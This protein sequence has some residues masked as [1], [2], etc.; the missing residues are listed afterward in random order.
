[1]SDD[2]KGRKSIIAGAHGEITDV[3]EFNLFVL[4]NLRACG[5]CPYCFALEGRSIPST[6]QQTISIPVG[7]RLKDIYFCGLLKKRLFFIMLNRRSLRIKVMQNLFALQQCKDANYELCFEK[8][9]ETFQPDLNSMET[10]D[11]PL[12]NSQ[13]KEARKVFEKA[14]EA[15]ETSV[16]HADPAV[17]KVVNECFNFYDKQSKKDTEFFGKNLVGEVE[18]IYT[19]YI[20]VLYLIPAFSEIAAADKKVSHKNLVNNGWI[21]GLVDSAALKKDA[22]KHGKTWQDKAD[23]V[24]VWFRDVIRQDN[25]YL[26]YID[27]KNPTIEDQRKFINHLFKKVILGKSVIN[28]YFEEEVLRWA[29]DK[30]IVKGLVEKTVKS[31]DPQ[32]ALPLG[33][34]TLSVN[35]E[36]DKDFI[37]R[38]YEKAAH[39]EPKYKALVAANTRNWEVERLPLTDRMI[40]EMAIAEMLIFP[41]IPVKVSM[42]EYIEL[43]KVYSTPKSR[44]FINGILDVIAKELKDSG[45]MKKSGRGL[46]DNK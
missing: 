17:K 19:H 9:H 39:L 37:E 30:D 13:K 5:T 3:S 29:E 7:E 28:E 18:K 41:G 43:A 42:N 14:F 45:A 1:M 40:I 36:D 35:W 15:S 10:Q 22:L 44:Q 38:L 31:Y 11:K 34:H 32:A 21:K 12:L 6:I 33:L 26:N 25:E 2:I 46:I 23:R 8:I 16:D 4:P 27:K 24:K 20:A